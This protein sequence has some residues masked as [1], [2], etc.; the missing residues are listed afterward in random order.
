[1]KIM[2]GKIP[3]AKKVVIYGPEGIGKS[4]FASKFPDPVFIDTEGSTKD[5]DVARFD[6]P[7]SWEML[8][9]QVKYARDNPGT[10]KSLI[11]D[12]GDWAQTLAI[13]AICSS[14]GV[15]GIEDFGYGKGYIYV[16]EKYGELINLLTEVCDKGIHTVINCHA[17][18]RKFEQPDEMGAYDRWELKL[19][20]TP[21]C[22]VS[23]M[24][25]EWADMVLFANY[26]TNVVNVDP[27]SKQGKYKAQGGS[28]VMYTTHNPC[29][30]A[31]N[32]YGLPEMMPFEYSGIAHIIEGSGSSKEFNVD[33]QPVIQSPKNETVTI[34]KKEQE[35]TKKDI[36][37]EIPISSELTGEQINLPLNKNDGSYEEPD[38]TI[39]KALR[40]LMIENKVNEWEIENVVAE[41]GY[42]PSDMPI[43]DYPRDFIDGVLVGAWGQ[44]YH[45]I[46][47]ARE[48]LEIPFN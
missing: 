30:D 36:Q 15:K 14:H 2:K 29:W 24:I 39:P 11:I 6:T 17:A 38:I 25:K 48:N 22:S 16:Y 8:L 12:T 43:K 45:M 7:T 46:K 47:D 21:K 3:S 23:A 5:M 20:N 40:D 4:T 28:R 35:E 13:K 42:F 10:C 32:R 27:S 33:Q 34:S 31:K 19:V 1:M 44:V 18:M 26:K 9:A 37:T 41:K